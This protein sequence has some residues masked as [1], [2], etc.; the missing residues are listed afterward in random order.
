MLLGGIGYAALL[1]FYYS[2]SAWNTQGVHDNILGLAIPA[3][4]SGVELYDE[5]YQVSLPPFIAWNVALMITTV[6][7]IV[8]AAR[9]VRTGSASRFT[10]GVLIVKLAAI[11][12]FIA[13]FVLL[14]LNAVEGAV[15]LPFGGF[16]YLAAVAGATVLTYLAMASTS[17]YGWAGV[18]ALRRDGRISRAEAVTY[19]ALL[20]VFVVDIV[21]AVLVFAR[22]RREVRPFVS[23]ATDPSPSWDRAENRSL[24]PI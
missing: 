3:T 13:N 8:D 23:S 12:F 6:L 20:C 17:I 9:K 18:R 14:G 24:P 7:V 4:S 2:I 10:T 5:A 1:A 21:G 11:P 15:T 16:I 19:S 22:G